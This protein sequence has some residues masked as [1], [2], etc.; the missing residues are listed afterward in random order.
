MN[1]TRSLGRLVRVLHVTLRNTTN[2]PMVMGHRLPGRW[3][4]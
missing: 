4:C 3:V 1:L 2:V